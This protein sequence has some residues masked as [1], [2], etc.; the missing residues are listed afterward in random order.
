MIYDRVAFNFSPCASFE[1]KFASRY[2]IF[3]GRASL[4][5]GI[6]R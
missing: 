4:L 5:R 2:G 1:K 6:D 3:G